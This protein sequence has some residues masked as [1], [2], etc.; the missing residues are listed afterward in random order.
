MRRQWL[1][2][3]AQLLGW[4]ATGSTAVAS[5]WVPAFAPL[6]DTAAANGVDSP[7]SSPLI[8]ERKNSN[9]G[10]LFAG[11]SSHA[12]HASH[13]SHS[14]HYSGSGGG[15]GDD[16]STDVAPYVAPQP[17]APPPVSRDTSNLIM[18]VRV[19]T[20]LH[21]LG[22]YA[23]PIDGTLNVPTRNAIIRFKQTHGLYES[24]KLDDQFLAA[25]GI[26]Y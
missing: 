10:Q 9:E 5:A 7:S 26:T 18:V 12:S 1:T 22:F 21:E 2:Y 14:S 4:T 23:G 13:A 8:F 19:Q 6:S 25:L 11:H 24:F 16:Y 20:R 17:S 3:L 15:G